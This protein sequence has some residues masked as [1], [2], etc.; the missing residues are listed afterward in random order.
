MA[1]AVIHF[2]ERNDGRTDAMLGVVPVGCVI[3]VDH[4]YARAAWMLTL[5]TV[6]A[7]LHFETD[8]E[9]ARDALTGRV[10]QW[11]KAAGLT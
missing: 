1:G 2:E 9:R 3:A 8:T 11:L 10:E 7:G 5:P 6:R 4:P